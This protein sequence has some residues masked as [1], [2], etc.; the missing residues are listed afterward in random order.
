MKPASPTYYTALVPS[1]PTVAC[2]RHPSLAYAQ[3]RAPTCP[4]VH[5]HRPKL[6]RRA[7]DAQPAV[8]VEAPAL[9]GAAGHERARVVV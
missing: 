7:P 5:V 2:T 8:D 1:F 3:A 6:I 4:Q 9:D